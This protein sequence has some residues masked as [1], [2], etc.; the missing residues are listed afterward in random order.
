MMTPYRFPGLT[1]L[2][3]GGWLLPGVVSAQQPPDNALT[4]ELLQRIEQLEIEVR[5]LRGDL[6]VYR[7][8]ADQLRQQRMPADPVPAPPRAVTPA[9][10]PTSAPTPNQ[11]PVSPPVVSVPS[12]PAPPPTAPAVARG[13]AQ[14]DFDIA[15]GELREGRYVQAITGFEQFMNAH[16]GSNL[17]SEAQYWLGEAYYLSRDYN[18]AKEA[19]INLGLNY[20]QSAKLPDALLKL[21]Y[22]YGEQG[23]TPRARDV[24]QKL[25]QV[26]PN[27]PAARLAEQQLQSLR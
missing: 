19:F 24:L 23:D 22:L 12:A 2:L 21:G 9:P 10:A 6:D 13:D 26:Y 16:S 8:Q 17:A 27:T 18:A 11:P 5:Q 25:V 3:L 20:P 15:L 4:L 14:A 7:Y 1:V